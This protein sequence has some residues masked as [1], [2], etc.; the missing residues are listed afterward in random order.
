MAARQARKTVGE[1]N[2]GL[3]ARIT[4]SRAVFG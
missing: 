3:V 1:I 2:I 4:D